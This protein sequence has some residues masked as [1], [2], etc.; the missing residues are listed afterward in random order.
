M[1][2][3]LT[4]FSALT[5]RLLLNIFGVELCGLLAQFS[6]FVQIGGIKN[7]NP[8][9][10]SILEIVMS[11]ARKEMKALSGHRKGSSRK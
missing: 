11:K 9:F 1:K 8:P 7:K 6:G 4:K 5:F 2:K 3:K 10:R